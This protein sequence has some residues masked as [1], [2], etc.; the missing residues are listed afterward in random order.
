MTVYKVHATNKAPVTVAT[1]DAALNRAAMDIYFDQ[2][3]R[4]YYKGLL[5]KGTSVI[6]VYGSARTDITVE[7]VEDSYEQKEL[8]S[9]GVGEDP[10]IRLQLS[11]NGKVTKNLNITIEQFQA[12]RKILVDK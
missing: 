12:I 7:D 4:A 9:L 6:I 11:H 10:I 8:D 5:E 1:I 3:C 2:R